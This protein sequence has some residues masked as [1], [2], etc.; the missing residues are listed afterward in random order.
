LAEQA[1]RVVY[2]D[3]DVVIR[4]D[5]RELFKADVPPRSSMR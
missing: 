5:V 2:L 3:V 4:G 1:R